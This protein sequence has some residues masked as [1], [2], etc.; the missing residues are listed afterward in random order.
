MDFRL[1]E[2]A[3][4]TSVIDR[5]RTRP[6][7]LA[8]GRDAEPNRA[9]VRLPDGTERPCSKATRLAMPAGTLL[10]LRTGGGGGYG[11][12]AERDPDAVHADLRAGYVSEARARR[13]YPHAFTPRR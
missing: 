5:T 2:D 3:E 13:D 6:A 10:E 1:L 8:G 9:L 11:D 7:G 4:L 12:P